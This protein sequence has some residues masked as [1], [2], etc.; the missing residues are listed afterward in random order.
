MLLATAHAMAG[1]GG[2]GVG[3]LRGIIR[4]AASSYA[5]RHGFSHPDIEAALSVLG[6][7]ARGSGGD[8]EEDGAYFARKRAAPEDRLAAGAYTRSLFG[9]T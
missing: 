6:P 3:H 8:E 5:A 2:P 4:K 9:P 1:N 7:E